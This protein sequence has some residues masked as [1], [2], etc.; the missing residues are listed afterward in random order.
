MSINI[1]N[2]GPWAQSYQQKIS[3]RRNFQKNFN[4]FLSERSENFIFSS[5]N[6]LFRCLEISFRTVSCELNWKHWLA[7]FS[8]L[9]I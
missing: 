9:K 4:P 5:A 6:Y 1:D 7:K 2:I 3:D 8:N